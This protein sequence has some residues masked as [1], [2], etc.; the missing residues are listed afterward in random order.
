MALTKLFK[1][2]PLCPTNVE[3]GGSH[4]HDTETWKTSQYRYV[5]STN[6]AFVSAIEIT[7]KMF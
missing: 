2:L 1:L 6:I 4:S 5:L 7:G 3:S